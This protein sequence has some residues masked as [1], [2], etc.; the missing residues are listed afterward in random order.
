M[1]TDGKQRNM[2]S[3]ATEMW[4]VV[5]EYDSNTKTTGFRTKTIPVRFQYSQWEDSFRTK[6]GCFRVGIVLFHDNSHFRRVAT[7][8]STFAACFHIG[9]V[10][11]NQKLKFSQSRGALF[12]FL[13]CVSL[14]FFVF[15]INFGAEW[16]SCLCGCTSASC[17]FSGSRVSRGGSSSGSARCRGSSY[18]PREILR[19]I[20]LCQTAT[21]IIW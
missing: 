14:L 20:R 17:Y 9:F 1:E 12:H 10:F 18:S 2:R 21:I 4:I 6:T 3:D 7:H 11:L 15:P 13:L 5:K 19:R 16:A 8:I